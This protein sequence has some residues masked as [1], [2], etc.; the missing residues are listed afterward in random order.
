[1][2]VVKGLVSYVAVLLS[3]S[4]Q[5]RTVFNRH[6]D[7]KL[8]DSIVTTHQQI[9]KPTHREQCLRRKTNA[10]SNQYLDPFFPFTSNV[11]DTGDSNGQAQV[12]G[13]TEVSIN[14]CS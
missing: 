12:S 3:P 2:Q 6:Q 1:M 9:L 10:I 4:Q 7:Y 5:Q 14:S 8:I 13:Q 11:K